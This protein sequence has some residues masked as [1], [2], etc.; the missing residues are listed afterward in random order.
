MLSSSSSLEI[1][2]VPDPQEDASHAVEVPT[3]ATADEL[4]WEYIDQRNVGPATDRR[5][6]TETSTLLE[7]SGQ[8][9]LESEFLKASYQTAEE[10]RSL[11]MVA[12]NCDACWPLQ[13]CENKCLLAENFNGLVKG[14]KLAARGFNESFNNGIT[15]GTV[16]SVEMYRKNDKSI[17]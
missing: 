6:S 14:T 13:V 8:A 4:D 17:N 3:G 2:E 7:D 12:P 11:N 15:T 10:M 9:T 16:Y 5:Y 1:L